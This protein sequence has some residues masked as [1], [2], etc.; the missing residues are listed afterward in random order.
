MFFKMKNVDE[1]VVVDLGRPSS[2]NSQ[3]S[4]DEPD[5]PYVRCGRALAHD[6]R[7]TYKNRP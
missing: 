1:V 6:T 4:V 7:V 3:I 2:T 5:A